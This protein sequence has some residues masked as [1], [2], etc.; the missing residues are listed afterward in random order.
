MVAVYT[1][2]TRRNGWLCWAAP[3]D[4]VD[5]DVP[6]L[7]RI[8]RWQ[9]AIV[10][11]GYLPPVDRALAGEALAVLGDDRD[12]EALVTIPAGPFLMGS[13]NTKDE[14]AD[15]DEWPQHKVTLSAFKIGKYPVTKGQYARFIEAGGYN[16]R[17]WWT[18]A[19]WVAKEK[20][21]DQGVILQ[22]IADI[23]RCC[24][25]QSDT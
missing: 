25:P 18:E 10:E 12:F 17:R 16:D 23:L 4:V 19:G 11:R 24:A 22:A 9:R 3:V 13:D 21:W 1:A 7:E 8:R 2:L 15:D 20:P 14:Q 6:K 5:W